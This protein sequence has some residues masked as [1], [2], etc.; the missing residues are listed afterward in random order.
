VQR[1]GGRV[2]KIRLRRGLE[3][4]RSLCERGKGNRLRR[5]RGGGQREI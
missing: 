3:R 4:K 1:R 2:K 5:A